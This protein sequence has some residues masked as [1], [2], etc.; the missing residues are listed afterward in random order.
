ML[1]APP[2]KIE[3]LFSATEGNK[4]ASINRPTA[5][6]R[7]QTPLPEGPA[8]IQLYSLGTPNGWKVSILLEELADA[9][10]LQYD[11]HKINIGT[12]A[13]FTSGFVGVN[14]NSKIPA[15]LDK[16]GPGN[17]PISV[18]ETGSINLYLCEKTGHF[19]PKDLRLRTEV[20]NWTF[21]QMAGQGPMTGAAFG[22]F[23]VYAP[24][25]KIE[26]REYG[27][28]RYGME[29]QRLCSVLDQALEGKEYLVGNEYSLADIMC[30]PWFHQ[31]RTGYK[32]SSG[33]SAADFLTIE[34]YKNVNAWAD[35]IAARP[36]VQRGL[37]VCSWASEATKPWLTAEPSL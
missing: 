3:E 23:F 15:L 16:E 6:A 30:F 35:R 4:F 29:V 14:P 33:I 21:W 18:W 32:H 7:E 26:T 9:T 2:P 22:H 31:L 19:I 17:Q 37:Q 20:M 8:P 5:G 13:Q 27:I 24:E 28:A 1:F 10:G 11:A 12:G 34:Q 25:D 36:A